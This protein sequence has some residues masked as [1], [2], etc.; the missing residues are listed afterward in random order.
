MNPVIRVL[1]NNSLVFAVAAQTVLPSPPHPSLLTT[2]AG[3]EL[4][5]Q[6]IRKEA[7]ARR[8]FDRTAQGAEKLQTER[9]PTFEKDW[10]KEAGKRR[11]QDIYPEVSL[12][13]MSAVAGPMLRTRDAAIAYAVS[14][15][16]R[17]ADAVRRVL[18]HYASYEFF[19]KHPDVGMNWSI[20][21]MAGIQS[22]DLI[23]D[24]LDSADRRIIDGFFERALTA[25]L[26]ND[27]DWLR[28]GWGGRF[29]NHYA[30]HKLFIGTYGLFYGKPE[31]VQYAIESEEGF[32][33]LVENATRDDG[34]WHESSINYH[35]AGVAPIAEFA[36][37]LANAGHPLDLWNR[38]FANGRRVRDYFTGPVQTLFPDATIPTIGDTYGRRAKLRSALYF[39]AYNAFPDAVLGW[40]LRNSEKPP[41]ALFLKNI[42]SGEYSAPPLSTRTWP[43]HGYIALRTQ[44]GADYWK[45]DGFSA[46]LSF[47][48]DGIHSH[49]D[50]FDLMVFGRG[51]H[52]AIDP[53]A[54]ASAPHAFSARI[55]KEL[56]RHTVCHNTVMV[57]GQSH[58]AL[59][60]KLMIVDFIDGDQIK[61]ATIADLQ[62]LVSPGVKLMR[63][64]AATPGYVLDIFQAASDQEHTY[65]YLFHTYDDGGSIAADGDF[66]PFEL[67]DKPPWNW[68]KNGRQQPVDGDWKVTARQG[69][70][71]T[72][73][74][75]LGEPG[76]RLITCEFPRNDDFSKPSIPMLMAR[77]TTQATVFVGV[78]QAERDSLPATRLSLRRDRFGLLRVTVEDGGA[79]REFSVKALK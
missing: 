55:Q 23:F 50:K 61:L 3:L 79:T 35:F 75:M 72:R 58:K 34:L 2:P 46:F 33:D 63:T 56:N 54:L 15:E 5:R 21:C 39:D 76:T 20:W 74:L 73:L 36:I 11:W 30:H 13:T 68:L 25:I 66:R 6:R 32:R 71:H 62:G 19:A 14:G 78:L 45:G 12:H 52:I 17:Y 57:D 1:L 69:H 16:R 77:R 51:A 28:E 53:E 41:T 8:V 31:Y 48:L 44:E 18:L 24:T 26:N 9:L 37:E 40:V 47:D 67:G 38:Q 43:E 59:S 65:D 42:P 49:S 64:V 29:N 4:A 10:W 70:L 22:Y 27:K 7:W 60:Q